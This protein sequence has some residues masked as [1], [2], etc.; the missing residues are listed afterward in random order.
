MYGDD[1]L[2]NNNLNFEGNSYGAEMNVILSFSNLYATRSSKWNSAGY[3]G[4]G[5]HQYNSVLY[6]R[7]TDG[8]NKQIV[9][10]GN[11]PS[12]SGNNAASSIYLSAQ[13]GIKRKLSKRLDLE[14]RTGMYFNYDDHL[15]ATISNRQDWETFFVSSIGL[16]YKLGKQ[17]IFTLWS[18]DNDAR[19]A[20]NFK[21][22][23]T[24]KDGVMDQLDIEPNTPKGVMVY[25]NGKAIDSD[26]DGLPD[27]K[28]KCPL[29]FGEMS[30]NGCPIDKDT[31]GD[32][33]MDRKDLC[34]ETPGIAL[35]KGC[36]KQEV[37][38]TTINQQIGILASSIYFE[39]NSSKIQS[40]SYVTI[41]KII[42]LIKKV[43]INFV[44]EGHTDNRNSDKYNLFLSQK[45]AD[46]VKNYMVSKGVSEDR[47]KSIGFGE[48][49]PKFSNYNA[50][51]RQ[52]NRRVE[53]K[54][55]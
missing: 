27:Y 11:N 17:K 5:F 10:F 23:D 30:N 51:G 34:P 3:F 39:T 1:V 16:S 8:T 55:E 7:L 48:S 49:R 29:E 47:L 22:I 31:D 33:V 9:D 37:S 46:A 28:D 41:D 18:G 4:I 35:N 44:I 40:I 43:D 36:P 14:F 21:I 15:D 2:N 13:L 52:L 38:S 20:S 19:R 26:E 24:D 53:I 12:R 32:G 42:S 45:R 54:P 6:E 50:G 25:G